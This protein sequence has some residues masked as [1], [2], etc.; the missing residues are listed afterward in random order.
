MKNLLLLLSLSLLFYTC[1]QASE[2]ETANEQ[3]TNQEKEVPTLTPAQ[4]YTKGYVLNNL[5][6]FD[7]EAALKEVFGDDIQRSTGYYPEGLGE[8]TT[9]TLFGGTD[10]EV[11][12]KWSD[13]TLHF[14]QLETITIDKINSAWQT[15]DSIRIG[16]RLKTLELINQKPFTFLGFGWDYAGAVQ[17]QS[18]VL[19]N[20]HTAVRLD[21][22]QGA[23]PSDFLELLG[24]TQVSSDTELAQKANPVV[25]EI[26]LT[27]EK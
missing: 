9:T 12:F 21:L 13:D 20:S 7:S 10:N 27:R 1:Q 24:D 15:K 5:L 6:D 4:K 23:S 26:F 19:A 11:V 8:Y 14:N 3:T 25:V 22:P 17:W 16:T 18:G 2:Q